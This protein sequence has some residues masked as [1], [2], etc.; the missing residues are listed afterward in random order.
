MLMMAELY[1]RA[2]RCVA[3]NMGEE[4]LK[5]PIVAGVTWLRFAQT[6]SLAFDPSSG[7]YM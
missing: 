2:Q 4:Q 7:K 5:K 6:D 3:L 1:F